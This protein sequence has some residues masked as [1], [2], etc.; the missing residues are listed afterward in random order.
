MKLGTLN[1]NGLRSALKKGLLEWVR[2]ED[3]DILC[4]Q[5]VRMSPSDFLEVVPEGYFYVHSAAVK[6]GYSGVAIW[7]KV[8]PIS[9]QINFDFP[10]SDT[11]GRIAKAEF[12]DCLVYSMYFPSGTSGDAR[13]EEKYRFLDFIEA[14]AP[15][16]LAQH[17]NV[18]ICGDINIAHTELDIFHHKTNANTS[19]FL[20]RERKWLTRFLES[21]WV[22]VFRSSHPGE[23]VYSWWTTRSATAR[24]NNIGWRIDY[25][26][27]SQN[28]VDKVQKSWIVDRNLRLSDHTAVVAE[29][30]ISFG[31]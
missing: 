7:S 10:L 13:Q 19:G 6:P 23:E 17:K 21:G 2:E 12:R 5:E 11:E 16:F 4:L 15:I 9:T 1:V 27:A 20:P 14:N 22:D 24:P 3:F 31:Y 28:L 29:Y 26:L 25:Q 8:K 18:V 30:D